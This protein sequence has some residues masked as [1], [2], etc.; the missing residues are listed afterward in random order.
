M[1]PRWLPLGLLGLGCSPPAPEPLPNLD[2]S[3]HADAIRCT[4][5]F[6]RRSVPIDRGWSWKEDP[7][8]LLENHTVPSVIPL[9]DGSVW[10]V[11]PPS[12]KRGTL[13]LFRSTDGRTW[14]SDGPV[15]THLLPKTCGRMF[16]DATA[17]PTT[18]GRIR[19]LVEGWMSPT[20]QADPHA[21]G[22]PKPGDDPGTRLCALVTDGK[23]WTP[24][25]TGPLL[26]TDGSLWPSV[27]ALSIDPLTE[28]ARLF[29]ADTYPGRDAARRA[30][31]PDGI[32]FVPDARATVLP[33]RHVDP[34][35]VYVRDTARLRLYHT[36][37]AL[38]GSLGVAESDDG[39]KT[40]GNVKR[41]AG[42]SGQT[43][44]T[45]PE[46]PSPP[47]L[48]FFD[49]AFLASAD[50]TLYLYYSRFQTTADGREVIGIGR[51]TAT[52]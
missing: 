46:Q 26:P 45:P 18:D 21:T 48:C 32:R 35:P 16:L 38:D 24:E 10:M 52:D 27:P 22:P 37:D 4:P 25:G 44:H 28:K 11:T 50:G 2:C 34:D 43:C 20:G 7:S 3:T 30:T 36:Y 51:A 19:V 31:S 12:R 40:F 23:T 29:F 49:P 9:P 41:L 47:D 6:A 42:L 33:E 13:S 39:G 17:A 14:Q 1:N 15:P 5:T 8:F